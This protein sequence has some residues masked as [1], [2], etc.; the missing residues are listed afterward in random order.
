MGKTAPPAATSVSLEGSSRSAPVPSTPR[1]GCVLA[2]IALPPKPGLVCVAAPDHGH[3]GTSRD[4]LSGMLAIKAHVRS[5]RIIVDEPTDLPEGAELDLVVVGND[6]LDAEDEQ[7]LM[8]SLD[9]AL[10]DEDADRTVDVD[11]FLA[12]VR[13]Q[14]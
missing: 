11:D 5:G 1:K 13:A 6:D 4:I 7:A 14:T 10:D 8:A 3:R 2:R 12:E 9:R